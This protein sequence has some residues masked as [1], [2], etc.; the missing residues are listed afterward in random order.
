MAA[1]AATE[2]PA[3]DLRSRRPFWFAAGLVLLVFFVAAG[4]PPP[5]V[6][7]AHY[8]CRLKHFW[9][10]SYCRGD[11]FLDSPDAHFTVV[12]LFGWLTRILSLEATAWAG[13]LL[14][15]T[16]VAIGWTR[17]TGR[18]TRHGL[19]APLG[20]SLFVLLTRHTHFAGE[21]IIGGFEA[22]SP[23]YGLVLIALADAIDRRWNR[24]WLLLG[25]ASALHALVGGWSVLALG[26]S[27]ALA[28]RLPP[29]RSMAPGLA[30]GAL[31]ALAGVAPALL[32][33]R[34]S[35]PHLVDEANQIYVFVR[36]S[37]HLAPLT[38]PP[39]WL[40]ARGWRHLLIIA[41]LVWLH[42]RARSGNPSPART[43]ATLL[44]GYAWGAEAISLTGLGI[45][46]VGRNDP[47]WAASLLKYYWFRLADIATPAAAVVLLMRELAICAER[48]RG[49]VV[50]AA[51]S[52][53]A[54]WYVGYHAIRHAQ[55]P[56][57]PADQSMEDPVAWAQMTDWI[58]ENTPEGSRFLVPRQSHTFK[59][60]AER[61]EVV[62]WKDIPQDAESMVEWN[63]R[64]FD[65]FRR[66]GE[67][68]REWA[69]SLASLGATRLRELGRQYDAPYVLDEAPDPAE[70]GPR[71]SLPVVHR[72][73]PYTLYWLGTGVPR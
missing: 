29:V 55:Q 25:G 42:R 48:R 27:A 58:R 40:W 53:A 9:D 59:W 26:V 30:G 72:V 12:W 66:P 3:I 20:A 63:R 68:P 39:E 6:N 17:L 38:K 23:A 69:E 21:W 50:V 5:R 18:V 7:E 13:R 43:A 61:P 34:D 8:L 60:R 16:L 37:H 11:L 51:A 57:P 52:V 41:A 10:A 19:L 31:L 28:R 44:A 32:L 2:S 49:A 64:Y 46:L 67:E 15:W 47:E 35:P 36:L 14:S 56:P 4:D 24:C 62:T 65:I 1:A 45:E 33:N 70:P 54:A 71:A 73:G 22:K